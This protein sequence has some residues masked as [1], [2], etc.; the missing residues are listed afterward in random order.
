MLKNKNDSEIVKE[1]FNNLSSV[2]TVA[3][4]YFQKEYRI[5]NDLLICL[6]ALYHIA[7]GY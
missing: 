2:Y 5:N 3:G 7:C 1:F 6:S 4:I